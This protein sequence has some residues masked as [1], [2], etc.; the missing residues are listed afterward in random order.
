MLTSV[1]ILTLI[2]FV[3]GCSELPSDY[4]NSLYYT[5]KP[6][7]DPTPFITAG[8]PECADGP[9]YEI[10][11]TSFAVQPQGWD[12][13]CVEARYPTSVGYYVED[14]DL[15]NGCL[16]HKAVVQYFKDGRKV[17]TNDRD[18]LLDDSYIELDAE[19]REVLDISG[20]GTFVERK[21]YSVDNQLSA[22]GWDSDGDGIIR[23]TKA[24]LLDFDAFLDE[25]GIAVDQNGYEGEYC[26]RTVEIAWPDPTVRPPSPPVEDECRLTVVA[27]T[28]SRRFVGDF[29][30]PNK[31]K[32]GYYYTWTIS[33][34]DEKGR[35]LF[36]GEY[37]EPYKVEETNHLLSGKWFTYDENGELTSENTDQNGDGI[38]E[39]QLLFTRVL[40]L[41]G[42]K[43]TTIAKVMNEPVSVEPEKL[44]VI[45]T[46][47]EHLLGIDAHRQ[48]EPDSWRCDARKN[49]TDY[50]NLL[51]C[52]TGTYNDWHP[53]WTY[54][55]E[56]NS[57]WQPIRATIRANYTSPKWSL[58]ETGPSEEIVWTYEGSRLTQRSYTVDPK[59]TLDILEREA[60]WHQGDT[61][62][63]YDNA[64]NVTRELYGGP[65]GVA[66]EWLDIRHYCRSTEVQRK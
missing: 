22:E 62:Y 19:G 12:E 51:P 45:R 65:A 14:N 33:E 59:N 55:R 21:T 36:V 57:A 61:F 6:A 39:L 13:M 42:V 32:P 5:S 63:E 30:P 7:Q 66:R 17:A 53:M 28:E 52:L 60:E 56:Y 27:K 3:M 8:P 10:V 48:W 9:W 41:D 35:P 16:P 46:I 15:P 2:M 31:G 18:P 49:I 44:I 34:L 24:Q 58:Y 29:A 20:G 23:G 11:A 37:T 64:G 1:R 4:R 40:G 26:G 43:T 38:Y 25:Q 50:H 47:N 54:V